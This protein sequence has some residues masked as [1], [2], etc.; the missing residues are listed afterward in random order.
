MFY[1]HPPRISFD[2]EF[3]E[4]EKWRG[5]LSGKESEGGALFRLFK[6]GT[7]PIKKSWGL[8]F[9]KHGQAVQS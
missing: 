9:L 8:G 5:G 6:C 4:E 7:Q 3:K 2:N 1:G